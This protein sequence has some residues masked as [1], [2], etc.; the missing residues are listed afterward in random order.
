MILIHVA[1]LNFKHKRIV[2]Y[3]HLKKEKRND[4]ARSTLGFER[5]ESCLTFVWI[6]G[7]TSPR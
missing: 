7:A 1:F 3:L 4:L 6:Q 5:S 2:R